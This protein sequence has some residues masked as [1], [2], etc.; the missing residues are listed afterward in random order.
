MKKSNQFP[1]A[2]LEATPR[3]GNRQELS[4]SRVGSSHMAKFFFQLSFMRHQLAD[5]EGTV[6]EDLEAAKGEAR[7]IIRDLAA[8]YLRGERRFLL[9][10]VH[11]YD[12]NDE[13]LGEVS[14]SEALQEF[15]P[16]EILMPF[17]D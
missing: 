16:L 1:Q 14:V 17:K 11:I 13:L 12:E 6:L 10:S 15:I 5:P 8:D 9:T 7:H 2:D 3:Y 4:L